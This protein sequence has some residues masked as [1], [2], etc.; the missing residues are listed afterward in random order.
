MK[1]VICLMLALACLLSVIS[2][3]SADGSGWPVISLS[4]S[5]TALKPS[6]DQNRR[7]QSY[8]GPSRHYPGAGA[9]KP[10]KVTSATALLR[11]GDYVLVDMSY[12]TV[13]RRI[14]YFKDTSLTNASVQ[15]V[16]L[17]GYSAMTTASVQP[18]FGPGYI[19]DAVEDQKGNSVTLGAW[20]YVT[21]FFEAD[22]WVFAEFSCVLGTIRAWLPAYQVQ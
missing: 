19:Y 1:K 14:L 9:Y 6:K 20:N 4:G 7:F 16:N 21:V 22:G 17:R 8:F 11:E 15:S 3:A 10:Y 13:G 18:M 2:F 12:K 5:G